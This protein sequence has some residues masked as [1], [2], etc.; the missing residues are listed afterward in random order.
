MIPMFDPGA[1]YRALRAEI[2]E[3]VLGVLE[4]GRYI[5]GPNVEALER[6]I[7]A[8]SGAAQAVGVASG[9]DAL[10]LALTALGVGPGDEVIVPALSFFATAEAVTRAGATPAFIDLDAETCT[11]DVA[12]VA[13]RVTERTK[14][15]IP[16]HMYGR[17]TDMRPLLDAASDRAVVVED[18]AQAFGAEY[19]GRRVGSIGDAGALSFFPTKNLGGFGDGG[20]VVTSN[21]GTADRLAILRAH[22]F[23]TKNH[24]VA[25]GLNSRLDELQAA[26]LRVKLPHVDEWNER[27]RAI[28]AFYSERIAALDLQ[29]P[30]DLGD[31]RHVYHLYAFRTAGREEFRRV[32]E[33]EG[34]SSGVYYPLPLHLTEPY[35]SLGYRPGDFP[36]AE[37]ACEETLA[38]PMYPEL[39]DA[40]V[41]RVANAV[42]KAARVVG[43]SL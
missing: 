18:C 20:M 10:V 12:A 22:G 3:A 9:T 4:S 29:V 6:E 41:E 31:G 23:R 27:R 30:H 7:A 11:I 34:V 32:L 25:V 2:D 1:Q 38:I 24:P 26:V 28:A 40:Q 43:A 16:V 15:I 19:A 8:Y 39:T 17:P 35:L 13:E 36:V 14:A 37:R 33:A 21:A 5:L 42:Q